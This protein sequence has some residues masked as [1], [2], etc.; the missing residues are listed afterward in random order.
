MR[1]NLEQSPK[2]L[3]RESIKYLSFGRGAFETA[4]NRASRGKGGDK[5]S[6]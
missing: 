2:K 6:P 4:R 5:T 1:N 3:L